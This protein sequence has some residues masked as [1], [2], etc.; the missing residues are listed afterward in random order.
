MADG[1]QQMKFHDKQRWGAFMVLREQSQNDVQAI[2]ESLK[3]LPD[4]ESLLA[5]MYASGM[6]FEKIDK[7]GLSPAQDLLDQV[8]AVSNHSELSKLQ[9]KLSSELI[10]SGCFFGCSVQNDFKNSKVESLCN[11][12]KW[13]GTSRS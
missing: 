13:V 2:F 12:P 11:F 7:A 5:E 1:S 9:G 4:G 6:N 3:D 10:E 8:D